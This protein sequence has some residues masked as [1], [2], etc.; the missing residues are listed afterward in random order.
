MKINDH[1]FFRNQDCPYFPCHKTLKSEDFNCMFCY[2]PLYTL[3]EACGGNFKYTSQGIKD[4]SQCILPHTKDG[5][6]YILSH[7]SALSDLAK[8]QDT[9]HKNELLFQRKCEK[10]FYPKGENEFSVLLSGILL[11]CR[12]IACYIF[13]NFYFYSCIF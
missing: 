2:C 12:N 10:L 5:Y 4:C 9:N 1:T 13:A 11:G 8:Q 6:S 7:F 3:G